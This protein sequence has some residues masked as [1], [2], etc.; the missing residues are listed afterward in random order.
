MDKKKYFETYAPPSNMLAKLKRKLEASQIDLLGCTGALGL[1]FLE[2]LRFY[3]IK[4]KSINFYIRKKSDFSLWSSYLIQSNIKYK[5]YY[6]KPDTLDVDISAINNNSTV[7][8]FLG[9][10]QP[11]KFLQDPQ[12]LFLMNQ[13][14]LKIA[15]KKPAN[16]FYSSSSEIYSGIRG[17]ASEF[18]I[19]ITTPS[20]PRSAY[21][22]S[23]RSAE[24]ILNNLKGDLRYVSFRIALA[25]PPFYDS[26]DN[27]IL[28]DL[29]SMALKKSSIRL[30]GGW[31]STRQYQWGPIC[32]IKILCAG[33]FGKSHL[34]NISG[35]QSITLEALAK[36]IAKYLNAQYISTSHISFD[37]LG[38]PKNVRIS[39][40]LLEAEL[41]V[42]FK[43]EKISDLIKVYILD[44]FAK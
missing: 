2:I 10:A 30:S 42:K 8:F 36:M 14:L 11:K 9:Y 12:S 19:P 39:S 35:G 4:P 34:Y 21:I 38:A 33:Y 17:V 16:I 37:E 44:A 26:S 23:K 15:L 6:F 25:S 43:K 27:R 5:I 40:G 22:E 20:H 29:F 1:S 41:G 3:N 18:S 31:D 24:A 7:L 32:V 13:L 28:A